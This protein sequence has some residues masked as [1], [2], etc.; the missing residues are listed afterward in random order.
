MN[1]SL[2]TR[3]SPAPNIFES[4]SP[5]TLSLGSGGFLYA[6]SLWTPQS[7]TPNPTP[8]SDAFGMNSSFG[9]CQKK[10]NNFYN[11]GSITS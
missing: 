8:T 2:S 1:E 10:W 7:S 6:H 3:S 5:A 9:N 4:Q 11:K